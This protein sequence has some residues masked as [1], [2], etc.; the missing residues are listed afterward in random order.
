[1][2][3]LI[4]RSLNGV[5]L[6]DSNSFLYIEEGIESSRVQCTPRIGV[7]LGKELNWRFVLL[8]DVTTSLDLTKSNNENKPH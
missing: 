1:M 5:D 6:T 8:D 2:A 4:D 7:S 3:L